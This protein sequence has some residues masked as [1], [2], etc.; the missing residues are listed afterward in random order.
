[1]RES[2]RHLTPT[3]VTKTFADVGGV[4]WIR[5]IGRLPARRGALLRRMQTLVDTDRAFAVA[6]ADAFQL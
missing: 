3:V 5:E 2:A 6:R 4:R 1:M